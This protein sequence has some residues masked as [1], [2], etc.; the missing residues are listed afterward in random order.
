MLI[1]SVEAHR[2]ILELVV[3]HLMDAAQLIVNLRALF[4]LLFLNYTPWTLETML[5]LLP[6]PSQA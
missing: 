5:V 2:V 1:R 4:L 6:S 3:K